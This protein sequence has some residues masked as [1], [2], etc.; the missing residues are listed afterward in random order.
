MGQR[1]MEGGRDTVGR[2]EIR[3]RGAERREIKRKRCKEKKR[4]RCRKKKKNEDEEVQREEENIE[5]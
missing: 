5:E 3:Q 2:R 4:K 1:E